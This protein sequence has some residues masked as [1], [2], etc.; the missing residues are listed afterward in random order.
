[1]AEECSTRALHSVVWGW[2]DGRNVICYAAGT[3]AEAKRCRDLLRELRNFGDDDRFTY[4][5]RELTDEEYAEEIVGLE[6]WEADPE[7]LDGLIER[8][9][10]DIVEAAE[11]AKRTAEDEI[12]E[13][14]NDI[15]ELMERVASKKAAIAAIDVRLSL[16]ISS[17]V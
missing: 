4:L 9:Q 16:I 10:V 13:L 3:E 11:E 1:M 7:E 6:D 8:L 15:E 17:E 2:D 14:E 5:V 12:G